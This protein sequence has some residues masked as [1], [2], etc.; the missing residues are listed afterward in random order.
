MQ[1]RRA[2][3]SSF[4]RLWRFL[5]RTSDQ[6][7]LFWMGTLCVPVKPE[8]AH[9]RNKT[10]NGM[11][12]IYVGAKQVLVLDDELLRA[13]SRAEPKELLHARIFALKWNSRSW[14]L[15]GGAL[16]Q[17]CYF[18]F[19]D[20]SLHLPFPE[21]QYLKSFFR[22]LWRGLKGPRSCFKCVQ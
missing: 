3:E 19:R 22:L 21:P 14:T 5:W 20:T 1:L 12:L 6:V 17:K 2:Q 9:L 18:R 4:W 15:Q 7:P 10:I 13:D 16:A 11:S 8:H